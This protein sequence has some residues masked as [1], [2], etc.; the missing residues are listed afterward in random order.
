MAEIPKIKQ[1]TL[2]GFTLD[3]DYFLTCEYDDISAAA[4]ELPSVIEWIN[5][6][7]QSY[8][9]MKLIK[10]AEV[11][12]A[13]ARAYFELTG[14]SENNLESNYPGSKRTETALAHAIAIDPTVTEAKRELAVLTGWTGRLGGLMNSLQSRLDLLRSSEATRRSVFNEQNEQSPGGEQG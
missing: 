4:A 12:E 3:V 8:Q 9:E 13:E 5:E 7:L 10:K 2:D 1:L 11:S 14:P 6:R